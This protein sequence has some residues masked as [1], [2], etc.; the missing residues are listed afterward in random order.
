MQGWAYRGVPLLLRRKEPVVCVRRL[1][2]PLLPLPAYLPLPCPL[3]TVCGD[4]WVQGR[5]LHHAT[6]VANAGGRQ[7]GGGERLTDEHIVRLEVC[8]EEAKFRVQKAKAGKHVRHY[9][10]QHLRS[11]IARAYA[12]MF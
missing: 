7:H 4:R 1:N 9:F 6:K 2:M 5:C 10:A 3:S 11:A 8:V 12:E